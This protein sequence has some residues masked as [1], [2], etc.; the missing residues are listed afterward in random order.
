M[1]Q[2]NEKHV[3]PALVLKCGSRN[4]LDTVTVSMQGVAGVSKAYVSSEGNKWTHCEVAL[5]FLGM[6]V[7]LDSS[8]ACPSLLP[9]ASGLCLGTWS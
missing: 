8:P 4:L 1:G 7:P 6:A 5:R 3:F 2:N 9:A